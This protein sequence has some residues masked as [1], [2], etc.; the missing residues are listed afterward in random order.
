MDLVRFVSTTALV[1]TLLLGPGILVRELSGRRI[2]L[3]FLPLA[4]LRAPDR[5]AAASPGGPPGA[6]EPRVTCFAILAPVL[7]LLL[8]GLI[9]AGSGDFLSS[10]ER[11]ILVLVS[12]ALGLVLA[13]SLWSLGPEGELY[14]GRDLTDARPRGPARQPHLVPRHRAGRR[15][16]KPVRPDRQGTLRCPTTSPAVGPCPGLQSPRSSS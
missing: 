15:P 3:A 11:R 6:V 10:E 14:E 2:G 12:L 9:G 5:L 13:R 8:G 16:A 4:R 1:L 7:G